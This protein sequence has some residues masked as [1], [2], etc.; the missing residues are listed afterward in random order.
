MHFTPKV[1]TRSKT[2]TTTTRED[3]HPGQEVK[4]KPACREREGRGS[5]AAGPA[6]DGGGAEVPTLS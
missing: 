2:T 4:R 1:I 3:E 6:A 5:F